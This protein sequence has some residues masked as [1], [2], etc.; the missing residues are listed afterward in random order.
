M[1]SVSKNKSSINITV[2]SGLKESLSLISEEKWGEGL[3]ERWLGGKQ[4]MGFKVNNKKKYWKE[5]LI[6]LS[7]SQTPGNKSEC[8]CH[9][10]FYNHTTVDEFEMHNTLLWRSTVYRVWCLISYMDFAHGRLIISF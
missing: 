1:R 6:I 5:S 3:W 7:F 10:P 8:E 4:W 9:L 2:G